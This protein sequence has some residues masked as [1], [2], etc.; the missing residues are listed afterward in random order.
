MPCKSAGSH[1]FDRAVA[2]IPTCALDKAGMREQRARYA[3]LASSVTRVRREPEA[4]LIEFDHDVD[5]GL[6][7]E[8]LSVERECCPFFRFAFDERQRRLR[9][10]VTATAS[11]PAL[12]AIVYAMTAADRVTPEP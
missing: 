1:A 8:A 9:T 5:S 6:L 7:E 10:T 3:R 2:R 11:L 12:D 4:V